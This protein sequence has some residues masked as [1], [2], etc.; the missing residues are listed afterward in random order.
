MIAVWDENCKTTVGVMPLLESI[1]TMNSCCCCLT[2]QPT[3]A[4]FLKVSIEQVLQSAMCTCEQKIFFA[5][6]LSTKKWIICPGPGKRLIRLSAAVVEKAWNSPLT[7]GGLTLTMFLGL[8]L[9]KEQ[10][11]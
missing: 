11:T 7:M 6:L 10:T 4:E 8:L 1:K 3:H 2:L 9:I 5:L